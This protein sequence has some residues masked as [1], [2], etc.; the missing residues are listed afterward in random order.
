MIWVIGI[1]IFLGA[2]FNACMDA[3]ENEPNYNESIFKNWD[4]K[5]WCKEVSWQ[6]AKRL[7]GYKFDSWHISKSLMVTCMCGAIVAALF[8]PSA[9][10]H[11]AVYLVCAGINWNCTFILFYHKVF[12]IK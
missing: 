9:S 6:Y 4:K 12:K 7:W 8:T 11:W 3:F 1:L 5:F 10:L 2:F